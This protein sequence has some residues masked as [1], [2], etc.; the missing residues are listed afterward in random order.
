MTRRAEAGSLNLM[1]YC[2]QFLRCWVIS[3][4]LLRLQ[5]L[6]LLLPPLLLLLSPSGA[7]REVT[8]PTPR[9]VEHA[10]IQV[11]SYNVNSRERYVCHSGFK[12]KAGTSSLTEC[13]LEQNSNIAHWTEPNLKCI[14]D[15]SLVHQKPPSSTMSTKE[16]LTSS[17]KG[18]TV[19]PEAST[20]PKSD[21]TVTTET[22]MVST[23]IFF[24]STT[25]TAS[26]AL[27]G[28]IL[29]PVS[30]EISSEPPSATVITTRNWSFTVL[31]QTTAQTM[32]Q[33]SPSTHGIIT[34]AHYSVMACVIGVIL[35]L[36][37]AAYCFY[38]RRRNPI[39][40][41]PVEMER[42][43]MSGGADNREEGVDS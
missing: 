1:A 18:F 28:T 10:D 34:V 19:E 39:E 33:S 23:S 8:C 12:R 13:I 42:I 25:Y 26:P 43:P 31:A 4:P 9:S 24:S 37:G 36:S 38:R 22:V 6:L 2:S 14:R 11:K 20:S 30:K 5:L 35:F 3:L 27:A 29:K 17:E 41:N 21:T 15:P 7:L 16:L 40:E 32:E